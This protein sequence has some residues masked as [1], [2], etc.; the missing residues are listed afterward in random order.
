MGK[1]ATPS[2]KRKA[3]K[4]A[5]YLTEEEV[6]RFF[7][8]VRDIRDRAIFRLIYHRGLRASEPG[9]LLYTDYRPGPGKPRPTSTAAHLGKHM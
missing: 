9:R 6:D 2:V 1:A 5:T 3:K 8:V 7:R 4:E